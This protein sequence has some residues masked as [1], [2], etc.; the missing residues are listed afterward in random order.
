MPQIWH[1]EGSGDKSRSSAAGSRAD[2]EEPSRPRETPAHPEKVRVLIADDQQIACEV[3][4]R[5]LRYEENVQVIGTCSTGPETLE[6]IKQLNPDLVFLDV[7]MPG[8]NGFEVVERLPENRR[9]LIIF[10]TA[11]PSFEGRATRAR[12]DFLLKPCTRDRIQNVLRRAIDKGKRHRD[13]L[14]F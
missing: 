10:V 7:Q 5:L 14:N 2:M 3:L 6:A 12:A 9:P 4:R 13:D 8:L 11:N 1:H